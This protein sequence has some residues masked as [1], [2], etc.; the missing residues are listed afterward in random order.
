M[1]NGKLE[2][3]FVAFPSRWN[4]GDNRIKSLAELHEPIADNEAIVRYLMVS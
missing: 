4:A 3:C 1:H 2:V